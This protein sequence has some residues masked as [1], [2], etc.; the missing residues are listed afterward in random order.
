MSFESIDF[1]KNIDRQIVINREEMRMGVEAMH[2]VEN[3][4]D[5]NPRKIWECLSQFMKIIA[6][7]VLTIPR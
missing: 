5:K 1:R 4:R 6:A 3:S 7:K 2:D